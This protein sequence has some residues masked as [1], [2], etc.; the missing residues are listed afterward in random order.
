MNCR[1]ETSTHESHKHESYI[2]TKTQAEFVCSNGDKKIELILELERDSI[3]EIGKPINAN[4]KTE[5]IDKQN[6]MIFGPG[7]KVNKVDNSEF[8]FTI[9]PIDKTL[10]YEKL[11]I[12]VTERIENGENFSHKFLVPTKQKIIKKPIKN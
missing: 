7:I 2:R 3:L 11:E 4:L 12:Q 5:N 8:R 9:T 6:L 10:V 1:Y